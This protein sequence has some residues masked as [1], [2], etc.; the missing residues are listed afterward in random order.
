[1]QSPRLQ[2]EVAVWVLN[3]T[4]FVVVMLNGIDNSGQRVL[5]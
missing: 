1:M 2:W 3:H 5:Q 4:K